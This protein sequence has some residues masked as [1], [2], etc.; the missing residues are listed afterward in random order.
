VK[1]FTVSHIVVEL[2]GIKPCLETSNVSSGHSTHHQGQMKIK[3]GEK[4]AKILKQIGKENKIA[5]EEMNES[6]MIK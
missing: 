4:S 1:V 5:V 2:S 6:Q 3:N